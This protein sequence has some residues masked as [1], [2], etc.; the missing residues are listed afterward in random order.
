[1][2][3]EKDSHNC[4]ISIE[5]DSKWQQL[6]LSVLKHPAKEH[7]RPGM[8]VAPGSY[9]MG[10]WKLR[11]ARGGAGTVDRT[12]SDAVLDGLSEDPAEEQDLSDS[13]SETK[14]RLFAEYQQFV[15]D[16]K[17]KPL[18][19]QVFERKNAKKGQ[20]QKPKR[21]TLY[22]QGDARKKVKRPKA[23]GGVLQVPNDVQLSEEQK[24]RVDA[25]VKDHGRRIAELR[26][27]LANVLTDEQK[28]A[29]AAAKKKALEDGKKGP[30]LRES[31]EKLL[32]MLTDD[33]K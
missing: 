4:A 9:R 1:M 24:T 23:A 19:A 15:A 27:R 16:R 33:Q 21:Q 7:H 11:F 30:A 25:L 12:V 32:E 13:H 28:Q 29:R 14:T 8:V 10:D 22:A 6:V 26:A 18:A 2:E 31:R 17:L 5:G 3:M 20:R